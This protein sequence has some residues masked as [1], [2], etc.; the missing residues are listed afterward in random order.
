MPYAEH[1]RVTKTRAV[2]A[3]YKSRNLEATR[4]RCREAAVGYRNEIFTILG[5][6]C[7]RCGFDDRR[8]LQVDHVD[9]GGH[10][11]RNRERGQRQ[12]LL[13][14]KQNPKRFQVLCANCNVIKRVENKEHRQWR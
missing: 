9:G 2:S 1:H 8:A 7:V 5:D 4:R 14:V 13:A 6:R 12:L 3:R 11:N 10:A